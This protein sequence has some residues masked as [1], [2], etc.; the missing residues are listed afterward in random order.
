MGLAAGAATG[1][2]PE[3]IRAAGWAQRSIISPSDLEVLREKGH[4]DVGTS[5]MCGIVLSQSCDVLAGSYD[6]EP[7]VEIIVAD[8]LVKSDWRY[9]RLRNPRILHLLLRV[10]DVDTYHE[11][12]AFRRR[13]LP[14]HL[15]ETIAPDPTR[16]LAD[17]SGRQLITWIVERYVRPAF[18]DEFLRRLGKVDKR[19]ETLFKKKSSDTTGV[20]VWLNTQDELEPGTPYI[21][22]YAIVTMKS[23]AFADRIR[24][25][26]AEQFAID[27]GRILED[28][29]GIT[30][31][32]P[33]VRSE[34]RFSLDD[35]GVYRR[36]DKSTFD[37]V[38]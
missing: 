7:I 19:L 20:W 3:R 36:L 8:P 24:L 34:S 21:I 9:V 13:T 2:N 33:V 12:Q 26:R 5:D 28:C 11:L 4:L 31:E 29:D 16:Q 1:T 22:N 35:L 17:A 25:Q 18:P 32:I 10:G 38:E 37:L 15:L 30:I 27:L 6:D 14:R 23:T